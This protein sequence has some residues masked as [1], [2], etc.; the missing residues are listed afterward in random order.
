ML[1]N[2]CG[3]PN[4]HRVLSLHHL[5]P[6]NPQNNS[7]SAYYYPHFVKKKACPEKVSRLPRATYLVIGSGRVIT[8]ALLSFYGTEFL[9][10]VS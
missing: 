5:T 7:P 3:S 6:V 9:I 4:L 8:Q 2:I 10:E 1:A